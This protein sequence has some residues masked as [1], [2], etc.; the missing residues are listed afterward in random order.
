MSIKSISRPAYGVPDASGRLAHPQEAKRTLSRAQVRVAI[1][2][3]GFGLFWVLNAWYKLQPGF[4]K[5]FVGM[6]SRAPQNA[7]AWV[8]S[9]IHLWGGFAGAHAALAY[10]LVVAIETAVAAALLL[11]FARRPL[12][13]LGAIFSFMIW[14]VPEA[15]GRFWTAGQTDLGDSIMYSFI[16]LALY[17]V[18]AGAAGGGWSLDHWIAARVPWWRHISDP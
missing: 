17:L 10:P 8:K 4:Q 2:R 18:D 6:V 11:G 5:Q 13:L 16:F 15:F 9:W 12:Y 1:F 14:S 3:I 7:P